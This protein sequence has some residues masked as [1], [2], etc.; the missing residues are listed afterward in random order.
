MYALKNFHVF[1]TV[2]LLYNEGRFEYKKNLTLENVLI[3]V[4]NNLMHKIF[5]Y[6]FIICL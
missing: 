2:V 5:F 1:R 6:K 3:L 4:I